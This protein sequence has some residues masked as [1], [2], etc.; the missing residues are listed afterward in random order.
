[1]VSGAAEADFDL[2]TRVNVDGTRAVLE[3]ARRHAS[4]GVLQLHRGVWHRSGDR[5]R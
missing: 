2:G 5:G 3:H 1:M 4:T